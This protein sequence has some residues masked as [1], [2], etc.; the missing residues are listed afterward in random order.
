MKNNDNNPLV[1]KEN[2]VSSPPEISVMLSPNYYP[3]S[4]PQM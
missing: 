2:N 4:L 3:F 1:K